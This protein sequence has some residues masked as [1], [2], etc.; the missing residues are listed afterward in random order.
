MDPSQKYANISCILDGRW[1][2]NHLTFQ[3][4]S[5]SSSKLKII[6]GEYTMKNNRTG[7]IA[8][9]ADSQWT[10]I[11]SVDG[12]QQPGIYDKIQFDYAGFNYTYYFGYGSY[13]HCPRC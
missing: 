11:L 4:R 6:I 7:K 2:L 9:L 3:L 12:N 5:I 10:L 8:F 13:P 1:S